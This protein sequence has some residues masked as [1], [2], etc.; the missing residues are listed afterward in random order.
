M[1]RARQPEILDGPNLSA[2]EPISLQDF[3]LLLDRIFLTKRQAKMQP[4]A[5]ALWH[6]ALSVFSAKT[7]MAA[8]LRIMTNDRDFIV[9]GDLYQRCRQ[10]D[11]ERRP[12]SKGYNPYVVASDQELP[13]ELTR[14]ELT[15]LGRLM[16]VLTEPAKIA[17]RGPG[18]G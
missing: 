4:E 12:Q 17:Q 2:T 18:N 11:H 1:D 3:G 5:V 15:Q 9:L 10:Y 14:G 8:A 6:T 7:L 13:K 16:G